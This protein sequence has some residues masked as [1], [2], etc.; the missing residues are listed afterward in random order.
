MTFDEILDQAMTMLQRRG[1]L[2]Y[3]TLQLQFQLDD[4][5]L[6]ALKDELI[7]GQCLA[8]DEDG[9]VLVWTGGAD[10]SSPTSSPTPQSLQP[11]AESAPTTQPLDAER[12]QLTVLFCDLVDSTVLA[13]QLDPE[14]LREVVRAYQDTC[15]KVIARFEGHIAQ[16]LGDGL[17]VYFGYPR[18]HEDDAQ[19]AVRA[20][21]GIVE[22][23]GQLN[24]RLEREQGIRLAVRIGIHTGLVVVGAMGDHGRQE[25]L[26]LGGTPNIAARLQGLAAPDTVVIS[27][28]TAQLIYGYFVCQPLGARPLKGLTQPLQVYR[29]LQSSGVQTRLDIAMVRGL[30]PLVGRDEECM[31]LHRCWKQA[32]AGLGQVVLLSGEAGIGKSRLVQVLKDHVAAEPHTRIEWRGVSYHQQS[33]F[34]PIIDYLY[35]LLRWHPDDSPAE[36]LHRLEGAL[37]ASGVAQSDAVPLLAAL[38]SLP[39]P[40]SY[41]P[42]SLTPQRQ[43]QRMLDLLLAW[44][45]A[46]TQRQPVL[47]VVEDLHWVDPSTLELI[48]LLIDQGAQAR[49]CLILTARPEFHPSWAMVAHLTSLTLRRLAPAQVERVATHVAGDKALPASILQEVVRKTDGVPLFVEELTKSVLAS[50][51]L[52]ELEDGYA[53]P[54]PL[55][56]LA[57]PMTLH[58]ALMARLDRLAAVKAVAQLGAAIGR[59]FAYELMQAVAQLD[60]ATLQGVLGQLVEAE[61]VAQQGL[62]PQATYTFKHALVQDAAYQSLLKST[63]QQYHQRIAEVLEAQFPG[64]AATQPALLAHHY[65]E[66]GLYEQALS[67]WRRAGEHAL[68]RSA[69]QEAIACFEQALVALSYLSK[70]RVTIEQAIDLQLALRTALMPFGD[71]RRLLVCLRE[72]EALAAALD[73]PRRLAQVSRFL[74]L[75]FYRRGMLDQAIASAQRALAFATADGDIAQQALANQYLG[76]AYQ[77]HGDYHRAIDYLGQTVTC[78]DGARRRESFGQVILPAVISRA[79]LAWCHAEL[80]TFAEG[81]ALGEEGV[82]I[83]KSVEHPSSLTFAYLGVGLLSL[84]RG[85]LPIALSQLERAVGLCHEA[86]LPT[87]FP[88]MAGALGAAYILGE[89]VTD[90]MPLLTQALEQ[91]F[92]LDTVAYQALCSLPLGEAHLLTG[93]LEEAHAITERTLALVRAHQERGHEAYALRLLGEIAARCEPPE[94]TLAEVHYQQALALAETLGMRPLVAHC[95]HD[96]GTLYA[97]T[98]QRE[99]ARAELSTAI[100]LYRAMDMTFWLPQTEAALAQVEGR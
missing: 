85:D 32:T 13:S 44:L 89:R 27:A 86:N 68:G 66:A 21:L 42:L 83:A 16:Y 100:A 38:L 90:A 53:L 47:L 87:Y 98:G 6:D 28:T 2:T 69:Y 22:A 61:V 29:V 80:G 71:Y 67:A 10:V 56:P 45:H 50:G 84:R 92:A 11:Q 43:R 93:R 70:S 72:A 62:P 57:I 19:R 20:G 24:T 59:T 34:Y 52:Q 60:A 99:Q 81:R 74:S 78:L 4:A 51:L 5:H 54:G 88:R 94:R 46:E 63:R 1:R 76:Q 3:R 41:P 7:Y 95:H 96:L 35:R 73:D 9:R 8:V 14:D 26:A 40:A 18:A 77:A 25:Q 31:L 30:T 91:T 82:Q 23:M 65:M 17:L 12:R 64:T 48:S 55:P 15:A 75:D 97:A 79:Y 37:A 33:A 58:D 39:L 49:L 36:T